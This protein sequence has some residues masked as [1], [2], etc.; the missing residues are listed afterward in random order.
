MPSSNPDLTAHMKLPSPKPADPPD[1]PGDV[2][3]LADA[4]EGAF[5]NGLFKRGSVK[6]DV[7][8]RRLDQG[9][10]RGVQRACVPRRSGRA[11]VDTLALLECRKLRCVSNRVHGRREARRV[12]GQF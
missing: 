6:V 2:K 11:G 9:R 7:S 5:S 3:A 8:V 4:I 10:A 12:A 1:V